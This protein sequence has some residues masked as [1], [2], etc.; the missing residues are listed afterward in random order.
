M[1]QFKD[2]DITMESKHFIGD[3]IDTD[4]ILN[5]EIIVHDFKIEESKYKDKGNGKCLYLQITFEGNKRVVFNGSGYLM[6]MIKKIP[7][8][9]FPFKT[10]II[11]ES[12][13][14]IFS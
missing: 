12:K 1:K 2:F 14:L 8:D 9:G 13:R 7:K 5:Q 3:R 10:T 11:K 4:R 6:E